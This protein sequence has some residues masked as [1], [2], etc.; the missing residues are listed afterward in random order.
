MEDLH[1]H[2]LPL[3]V[4]IQLGLGHRF[5]TQSAAATVASDAIPKK[6]AK[7]SINATI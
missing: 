6:T 1:V 3:E 7:Q 5:L 2:F 4:W